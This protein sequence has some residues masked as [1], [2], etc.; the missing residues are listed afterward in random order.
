[1][2]RGVDDGAKGGKWRAHWTVMNKVEDEAVVRKAA[3]EVEGWRGLGW[4]RGVRLWM[5][6]R[7]G[8]WGWEGDWWF[9]G[10]GE[11]RPVEMSEWDKVMSG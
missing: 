6:G 10:E 2:Q 1:M 5:Y 9:E 4:A 3:E 8:R 7:G 11:E